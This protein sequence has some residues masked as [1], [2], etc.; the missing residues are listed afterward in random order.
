V[1]DAE[2][3]AVTPPA[4]TAPAPTP[5]SPAARPPAW[6][7]PVI[8]GGLGVALVVVALAA[9]E[10][11]GI[12]RALTGIVGLLLVL[13]SACRA[14][15][16]RRGRPVDV[17]LVASVGWLTALSAAAVLADVLPLAE[18]R[19]PSRALTSPAMLPPDLFSSHPLGTDSQALDVL[20]QLLYGA[21][22]SLVV[23]GGA[24][25]IAFLVGGALGIC[26][27]YFRGKVEATIGFVT[28]SLLAFPALILLLALVTVLRPSVLN[29][30][31][32]LGV[33]GTPGTVRLARAS[34]LAVA[35][36]EFVT[37]SRTLGARTPRIILGEVVPNVVPALIAY[38]FVA[39]GFLIVAEASLSFLGLGIQRPNPTWGNLISQGQAVLNTQ[40]W[41]VVLPSIFLFLTVLATN[42]VGQR[43]QQ[44][45]SM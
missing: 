36:R 31:I 40:P 32:A 3:T 22:V 12:A 19:D 24:V 30:T 4:R 14:V 35:S 7:R 39:I 2:I 17:S 29:V 10:M 42:Y 25:V 27:G 20:T 33:L 16:V 34:T 15:G 37:A 44:K 9:V 13:S 18:G 45:W 41:L 6:R 38:S 43:L 8:G 28:D 26:A 11:I 1:L 23:A 21:R 5:Q